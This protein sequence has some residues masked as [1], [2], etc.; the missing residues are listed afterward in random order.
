[1]AYQAGKNCSVSHE[2]I[3]N[4]IDGER[5]GLRR[6]AVLH[7]TKYSRDRSWSPSAP[8]NKKIIE[9]LAHSL[10]QIGVCSGD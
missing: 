4:W 1:M 10:D 3:P 8:G 2:I 6:F 5:I 9:I 7:N